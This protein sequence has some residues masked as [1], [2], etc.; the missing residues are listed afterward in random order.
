MLVA[1][2]VYIVPHEVAAY[3]QSN[4]TCRHQCKVMTCRVLDFIVLF[5]VVAVT[6]TFSHGK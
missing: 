2:L 4:D 3:V 1:E 6:V 5:I